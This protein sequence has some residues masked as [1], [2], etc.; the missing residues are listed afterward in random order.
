[1]KIW[2]CDYCEYSTMKA[3]KKMLEE[4]RKRHMTQNHYQELGQRFL[5]SDYSENCQS[6]SKSL[7]E[8]P[9]GDPLECLNCG[10]IHDEY[11]AERLGASTQDV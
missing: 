9:E 7:P 10:H 8:E 5:E 2:D 1:M 4:D 6:C 3:N 11:W